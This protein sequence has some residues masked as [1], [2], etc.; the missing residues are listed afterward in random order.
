M[1][2][3]S[4]FIFAMAGTACLF[5]ARGFV[6]ADSDNIAGRPVA[7]SLGAAI[8]DDCE[9]RGKLVARDDG[10]Y[11]V[12]DIV[13][14]ASDTEIK[15]NY[16]AYCMPAAS[17]VSRMMPV[18]V[19]TKQGTVDLCIKCGESV[20]KEYLI[21]E[22]KPAAAEAGKKET[23]GTQWKKITESAGLKSPDMWWLMIGREEIKSAKGWGAVG[24]SVTSEGIRLDKGMAVLASTR[25]PEKTK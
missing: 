6:T 2:N 11:A 1:K 4:A 8:V 10:T 16:A 7:N 23:A 18:P 22:D 20:T 15:F 21:R 12:F 19:M 5:F 17:M 13:N 3:V 9:I 24:P 25:T 14:S